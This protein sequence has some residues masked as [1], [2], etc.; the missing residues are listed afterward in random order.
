MP[1]LTNLK[2]KRK[3]TFQYDTNGDQTLDRDEWKAVAHMIFQQREKFGFVDSDTGDESTVEYFANDIFDRVDA[4]KDGTVSFEEFWN[5][6]KS[7]ADGSFKR[8]GEI[9]VKD[10]GSFIYEF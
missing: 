2:R 10:D 4:N 8:N 9:E 7:L 6:F 3:L 5:F 1:I